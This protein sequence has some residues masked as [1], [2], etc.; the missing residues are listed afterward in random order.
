MDVVFNQDKKNDQAAERQAQLVQFEAEN[1]ALYPQLT[2]RNKEFVFQFEKAIK[3]KDLRGRNKTEVLHEILTTLVET[4]AS[5]QTAQQLY[6]QPYQYAEKLEKQPTAKELAPAPFWM[7]WVEGAL[8]VGGLFSI[9]AGL[10]ALLSNNQANSATAFGPAA[11]VVNFIMGG[12]A[13]AVLNQ[14][15][16]DMSQEKGKRGIGRYILLSVL[17]VGLWMLILVGALAVLPPSWNGALPP[18]AYLVIGALAFLARWWFQGQFMG[19]N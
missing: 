17:V 3:D 11:L 10:S 14:Y 1:K 7:H 12:L 19:K 8:F 9:I 2:K 4:Q 6:G 13:M 16:P 18:F 15:S 5:G